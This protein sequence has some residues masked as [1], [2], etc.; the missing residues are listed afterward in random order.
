V[1]IDKDTGGK[2]LDLIKPLICNDGVITLNAAA[3]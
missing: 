3:K 2:P 1:T